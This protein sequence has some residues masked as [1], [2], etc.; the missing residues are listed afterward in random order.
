MPFDPISAALDI[1][2]KLIDR[3]W[4]DP[5]KAAEAKLELIKLQQSGELTQLMGQLEIN[6]TEAS[7][8]SVFVAGW[9]PAIGWTCAGAL[10]SQYILRPWVQWVCILLN[11]PIPPLPGIDDQLWQLLGGMLGMGSLRTYEK[12]KG[13][14]S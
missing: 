1:G 8:S 2:G 7:S 4:P 6:K 14:A 10:F 9:R 12:V 11:H 5:A 13:V 3:L